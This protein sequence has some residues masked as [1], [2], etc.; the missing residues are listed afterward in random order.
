MQT[1]KIFK[2]GGSMAIRIPKSINLEG[3]KEFI[4]TQTQKEITLT[5]VLKQDEWSGLLKT[6]KSIKES[7]LKLKIPERLEPQERE[8]GFK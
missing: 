3:I 5:P 2:S 7:N 6:L 4:I 8:W 1:A